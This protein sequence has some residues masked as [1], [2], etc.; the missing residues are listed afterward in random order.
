MTTK[1]DNCRLS[2]CFKFCSILLRKDI[3]S[4]GYC[5]KLGMALWYS[6]CVIRSILYELW[7]P[8][9]YYAVMDMQNLYYLCCAWWWNMFMTKSAF[10]RGLLV[11]YLYF[12][13]WGLH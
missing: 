6:S 10:R 11:G 2:F 1:L 12:G 7:E 3:N 8:V 4:V 13:S 9:W 5:I